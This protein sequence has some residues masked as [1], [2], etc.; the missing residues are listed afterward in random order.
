MSNEIAGITLIKLILTNIEGSILQK[1]HV[2]V[3]ILKRRTS[4]EKLS[5]EI[6]F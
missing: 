3:V 2:Y 5:P 4:V 6:V 1:V